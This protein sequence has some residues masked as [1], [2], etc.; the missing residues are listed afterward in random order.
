MLSSPSQPPRIVVGLL[1]PH[2]GG[3]YYG[4]VMNGILKA[5]RK[6]NA[7]AIAFETSRLRLLRGAEILSS[8]RVDGWLAINEFS[9]SPLLAELR[10][11][12]AMIVHV[13]SR[14]EDE[15]GATVL[16]DNEGG[17]RAVTAHLIW[18][19]HRRLAF[20]GNLIHIDV[21]E[22]YG[23]Y[24]AA[25]AAE[26]IPLESPLVF[27]T[28]HHK[29]A[30]GRAVANQLIEM[31]R[32]FEHGRAPGPPVTALVAATD[33]LAMGAIATFTE[34]G[35]RVPEDFAVVGFD[36]FDAA[37]FVD[38]PLTT[39]RQSF[40]EVASCAVTELLSAVRDGRAPRALLRV[41]TQ[42]VVRR[43]CGCLL[44]RSV[45][46]SLSG[47]QT[48]RIEGLTREL[49]AQ[50]G[51]NRLGSISIDEWPDAR[52]IA[53]VVEL[54]ARGEAGNEVVRA[55]WWRGFLAFKR[56]AESAVRV[57]ELLE[58]SLRAWS[59]DTDGQKS[60]AIL[61]DLRVSLMHEWQR[62]E[63]KM[64]S[65][66][67]SVTEAAYRLANAISHSKADP[68][69][70]LS[71]I[72][73]GNA[74]H[75][76]CALWPER[77]STMDPRRSLQPE[78]GVSLLGGANRLRVTGEYTASLGALPTSRSGT[79]SA[80]HFPPTQI[81]ETAEREGAIV[82]VASI[83]RGRGGEFGLLAVV[84]PLAFEHLEYVGT[85]GDWA[86]QLGAALDR[87]QA[88]RE[89][90][91]SAE[92]DSLT[93]LSNRATLLARINALRLAKDSP[94]FALLFIDLDDFK[95]VNDSLGHDAGDQLL[96]QIA[97]R[98]TDQLTG[99]R[100]PLGQN[101]VGRVGGDEFVVVLTGIEGEAD[102]VEIVR[103]LQDRLREPYSLLGRTVFV[104]ASIGVNFG[105]GTE[106]DA[107]ELL[108]D[109][110][111][112]MYRAKMQG[113]A[114]HEIF[115][116]GMHAQAVEKL[117]LD[118]RLRLAIEQNELELWYQPIINLATG[119]DVGAEALIR[120]RNPEQGLLSPARFLAVAEDVGLAI[121]I[122]EW[123]IRRAVEELA[124]IERS[125]GPGLY[126]NV[127]VPAAHIKQADFVEFIEKTLSGAKVS[128]R[129]FGIELV[130]SALL[131]EP[132][133]CA[134]ALTRLRSL[135]VRIAIDDFGT[136]YSSLAYLR[137][138]PVSTLKID[139]SF[140]TNVPGDARDNG[141]ARAIVAMGQ[142]LGLGIVAEGIETADQM[143]FL[144]Q[145]GCDYGQG[146]LMSM[147]LEF[148]A[149]LARLSSLR[150]FAPPPSVRRI[151]QGSEHP[152]TAAR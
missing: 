71:W 88:E 56:D 86:V 1:T 92:L 69:Q 68:S 103:A 33:R 90:R 104:S 137:D 74:Q 96:I 124:L 46:P 131:D 105:R 63:R 18:H 109:A 65:H 51:R 47:L 134:L 81:I 115:H 151:E 123:V 82:S 122:S 113:R 143:Q 129:S 87:A 80:S 147:P 14:P 52:K 28:V 130:E 149:Y 29:E 49:L 2:T 125:F 25:L 119:R 101:V 95:K 8:A 99:P 146:Y 19:G 64:V 57:M 13:H 106:A 107:Q 73:W 45:P 23:G 121:P 78:S 112:A 75:A 85:P 136:G 76:C 11:R 70:D 15:S 77:S 21:A 128:G 148:P 54:A 97:A 145:S 10:A 102:T 84:A 36:D 152:R 117:H 55:D 138:F 41:P 24:R 42:P 111:T 135:G 16:P 53:E 140:V 27:D 22:R 114:R 94:L 50:A 118:A 40:G 133:K 32:A 98:L 4:T 20:A 26:G 31:R 72:R 9:D 17:C 44:S 142:E 6:N 110:D 61:R 43:S 60:F 83:P 139:R 5:V 34:A 48:E 35:Y 7:V 38:P 59:G 126:V 144:K 3:F 141:I 62:A 93:G 37:Q 67:E 79:I 116:R 127:N 100:D 89:L 150:S 12:G 58:A 30:D 91:A 120:W 66:Y 108:R 39:V 132:A